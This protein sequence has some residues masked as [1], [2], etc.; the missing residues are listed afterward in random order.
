MLIGMMEGNMMDNGTRTKCMDMESSLG[1][2]EE[3]MTDN[4]IWIKRKGMAFFIGQMEDNTG[5]I[6][7]M[8]S[9][10][11]RELISIKKRSKK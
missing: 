8:G 10:M 7:R 3:L 1:R 4:T 5:E 9:R 6:G 11:E 2:M